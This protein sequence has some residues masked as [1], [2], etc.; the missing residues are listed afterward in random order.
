MAE[1]SIVC[2]CVRA[3]AHARV[4]ACMRVCVGGMTAESFAGRGL[5]QLSRAAF[6]SQRCIQLAIHVG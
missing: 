1:G 5:S 3:C 6:R 2:V 4:R